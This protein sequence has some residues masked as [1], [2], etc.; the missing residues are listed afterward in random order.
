MN[1]VGRVLVVSMFSLV[2]ARCM[3]LVA[4]LVGVRVSF[5]VVS[6]LLLVVCLMV[7]RC[8]IV[9]CWLWCVFVFVVLWLL[10]VVC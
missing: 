6:C 2:V 4:C 1:C 7:A 10:L 8:L 9:G 3:L 5:V